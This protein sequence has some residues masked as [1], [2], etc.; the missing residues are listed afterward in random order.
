M[1]IVLLSGGSGKRLWPLSNEIRS[2]AFL[3]LLDGE[4]GS[5]ESMIQRITRQLAAAG[6]LPSTHIVTHATQGEI[7]RSQTEGALS[8]LEEPHKRGTFT[9][10]ALAAAFFHSRLKVDREEIV[11]ALPVDSFVEQPFFQ[12]ILHCPAVLAQSAADL[13]L[14]GT[15]P[16]GPSSQFGYMVPSPML[17]D[18]DFR[19]I[20]RFVEKPDA[21]VAADLIRQGALWN[22]GV[23]AFRLGFMLDVM[24]ANGLPL[25]AGALLGLYGQLP[26]RS[27]D[28]EVVEQTANCAAIT[29][30]G[31]WDDLGNWDAFTQHLNNKVTG[32][33]QVENSSTNTHL[34]NELPC[35]IH[36]ID[37]SNVIVAAGPD[38]VLVASKQ[39]ASRIKDLLKN[40]RMPMMEEKRW[41]VRRTLDYSR[42]SQAGESL[43]S[44]V[45]LLAGTNTSYHFHQHRTEICA[46]LS[47]V[48]ECLM[49]GRVMAIGSGDVLEIAAGVK[50]SIKA[51]TAME[52][53]ETWLGEQLD[54]EDC[55]RLALIWEEA[56]RS[57]E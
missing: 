45:T 25:D 27:F 43:T 17:E 32:L 29:Y 50:H 1:Q 11:V 4:G 44:K 26:E 47:G 16:A 35:P 42:H 51:I 14:I 55:T 23:F 37:V 24:L 38:G 57:S 46:I 7:T 31:L 3:K 36:V 13:A 21:S 12:A 33:G 53:I 39:Q 10:I 6:L 20:E 54:G 28:Q 41:G 15:S 56:V 9:A 2:K 40:N 48:G 18:Q 19:R 52:Y 22:C 30:G 49:D 5:K 34:V 8:V